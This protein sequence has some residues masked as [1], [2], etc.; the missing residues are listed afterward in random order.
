MSIVVQG[1]MPEGEAFVAC[2]EAQSAC[3]VWIVSAKGQQRGSFMSFLRSSPLAPPDTR[4]TV[5]K[6]Y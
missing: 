2:L 4:G 5:S 6:F 3:R 1:G